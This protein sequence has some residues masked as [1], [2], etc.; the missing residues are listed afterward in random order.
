M[1]KRQRKAA[2]ELENEASKTCNIVALWQRNRNLD[3]IFRANIHSKL[4]KS[5]ERGTTNGEPNLS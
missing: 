2:K 3:L 5:S 4:D 1:K